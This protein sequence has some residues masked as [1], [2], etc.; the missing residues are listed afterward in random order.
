MLFV[1]Q[2]FVT[3]RRKALDRAE[4]AA[5][6][7]IELDPLLSTGHEL[8][9]RVLLRRR[10][11]SDA[12]AAIE[13]AVTLNPNRSLHY[14]SLADALTFANRP[15]EAIQMMKTAIRLNPFYSSRYNMYLGRAHYFS[16][17]YEKAATELET[18]LV[19]QPKRRSCYMYLAPTYVELGRKLPDAKRAVAKLLKI[20]PNYS[21]NASVEKHLPFVP[22]AM[23]FFVEGLRKAGVPE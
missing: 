5:R 4:D 8:L 10:R 21:I 7:T 2:L 22:S 20:S 23:Q 13:R 18:C 16:K 6:K 19:R 11:H 12:I 3:L 1:I 15:K 17:Q 14:A 9:G